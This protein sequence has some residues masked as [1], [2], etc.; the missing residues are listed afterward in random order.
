MLHL[1]TADHS[2]GSQDYRTNPEGEL[3][4]CGCFI[5]TSVS[6]WPDALANAPSDK[7]AKPVYHLFTC[8]PRYPKFSVL[9]SGTEVM[10]QWHFRDGQNDVLL[11]TGVKHPLP[12]AEPQKH[13]QKTLIGSCY[14]RMTLL[15]L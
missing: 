15:G 9:H 1:E 5:A 10:T 7:F 3:G 13:L 2:W 11:E 14:S 6:Q 12:A 4:E 8:R